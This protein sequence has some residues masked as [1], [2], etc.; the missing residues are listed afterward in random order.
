MRWFMFCWQRLF[1]YA[2][3]SR[4]REYWLFLL[5][6]QLLSALLLGIA[7]SATPV[8][9]LKAGKFEIDPVAILAFL[10][11]LGY[12]LA[13]LLPYCAV[14]VRRFHDVGRSGWW[15][16][17]VVA[18]MAANRLGILASLSAKCDPPFIAAHLQSAFLT[19]SQVAGWVWIYLLVTVFVRD[20]NPSDNRYG[21]SPKSTL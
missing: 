18:V 8:E 10:V 19:A 5:F 20:G 14:T 6:D 3:R 21:P 2:G 11:F 12:S 7:F 13:A 17:V 1:D 15:L 16:L 4:R 9:A